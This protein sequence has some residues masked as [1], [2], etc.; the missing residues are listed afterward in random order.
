MTHGITALLDRFPDLRLDPDATAPRIIGLYERGPEAVR[1]PTCVTTPETLEEATSTAWLS[2]VLGAVVTSVSLGEIDNRVSTN[3]PFRIECAD[4]RTAVDLWVKGYF[5]E[6]GRPFRFA[7]IPEAMFYRELAG[8][9]GMRT[10]RCVFAAVDPRRSRTSSSPRM[11]WLE[12]AVFL[13]SLQLYTADQ[14]ARASSSSPRCTPRLG[15]TQP[16]ATRAWLAS[17]LHTY[18]ESTRRRRDRREL[19]RA[20]R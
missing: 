11:S 3:A 10:L 15:C 18:T 2:E 12:G 4:G 13:D 1:G 20:D 9:S 5:S 8:Q 7:G 6:I 19:R 16:A 17:R 14:A